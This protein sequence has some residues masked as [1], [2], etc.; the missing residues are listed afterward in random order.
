VDSSL[1]CPS[2]GTSWLAQHELSRFGGRHCTGGVSS[3]KEGAGIRAG[4]S[5]GCVQ[6]VAEPARAPYTDSGVRR[7]W[8]LLV[9]RQLTSSRA[10]APGAA[11]S[12]KK[13]PPPN[14]V[15]ARIDM[16]IVFARNDKRILHLQTGGT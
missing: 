8:P 13:H 6:R 1:V 16:N 12:A 7:S 3:G 5:S 4:G 9:A 11:N 10:S 2:R 14:S 15:A